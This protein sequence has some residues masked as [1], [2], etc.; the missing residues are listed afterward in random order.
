MDASV[1]IVDDEESIRLSLAE[2][3]RDE[4]YTTCEAG[5]GEEAIKLVRQERPDIMLLD[6]RLPKA[7]GIEVLK[8]ARKVQ[9]DIVVIIMTAFADIENAVKCMKH[10]AY[11]YVDK[12]FSLE[13]IKLV[14]RNALETLA[15]K[16]ELSIVR[17]REQAEFE[18][19]FIVGESPAM[20]KVCEYLKRVARSNSSTVL[21]QGESGTG[22]ELAAR[23][24]HYWSFRR[25]KLFVDFNCTAVPEA[26]V[27]SELFGFEKGAFTD[28]KQQ[29]KGLFELA[30]KGTLFLDEIGDMSYNLQAKL[31]RALQERSFTRVGGVSKVSV[32]IR[33]IAS[34][35]R[36]LQAA[37]ADGKFRED[38]YYRLHVV[39][40]TLPPLR[41]RGSDV[42]LLA[43]HFIDR[44]NVEFK[45]NVYKISPEAEQMIVDY[46]WPGNVRELRNTIERAILL[47]AE[48]VLLPEHLLFAE[49]HKVAKTIEPTV[50]M[51]TDM[52]LDD[53][54][55]EYIRRVVEAV[56]WNKNR[57]AK[58]LGIDRTTLYT[59]IRKYGLARA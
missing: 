45:K 21:I 43:K 39:P 2:A 46:H 7:S 6:M 47:E 34:T 37:M 48:D 13:A 57:A 24:T 23:A 12:P 51:S 22:K 36:D 1:L 42:L 15:L 50:P 31:L 27:E 35:N 54:E 58:T 59:K 28:A 19:D 20:R 11:D 29:K 14:V 30:D 16:K 55:K 32:D 38:L 18:A 53:V 17:A 41:E 56:G 26:L 3:L 5:S 49:A 40:I 25:D 52:T 44:F 9:D 33:I 4:G 8:Q 10:G